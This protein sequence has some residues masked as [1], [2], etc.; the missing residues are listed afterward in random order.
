MNHFLFSAVL[1]FIAALLTSIYFITKKGAERYFGVFWLCV[2][3]WTFFVGFQFPI[4][5]RISAGAWGWWLHVGCISVPLLFYH[6]SLIWT[7]NP[8]RQLLRIGYGLFVVF[9]A[10]IAFSNFFTGENVFRTYY[11]YPKPAILYPI[12]IAYFQVYGLLST[13]QIFEFRKRIIFPGRQLLYIFLSVHLLAWAGS[14][15]NYLIMYDRL[16][17][18]LYPYGLYLILPYIVLGSFAFVKLNASNS[19]TQEV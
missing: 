8:N 12:Y 19:I 3:F 1:V 10:L 4:I 11:N 14:M 13:W 2:A 7:R 18:P 5:N 16:I 9:L 15:D 17:F 6:F